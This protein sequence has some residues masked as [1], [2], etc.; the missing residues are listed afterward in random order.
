LPLERMR[1][2]RLCAHL[3]GNADAAED[4]AHETLAEV[5]RHAHKLRGQEGLAPSPCARIPTLAGYEIVVELPRLVALV[6]DG[7]VA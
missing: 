1:L 3:S 5:W 2:V 7:H 4:L 6:R